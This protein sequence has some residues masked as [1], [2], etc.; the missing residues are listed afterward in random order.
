MTRAAEELRTGDAPVYEVAR[1][2][3]YD[4]EVSF[5]KAFTRAL[6]VPPGRYRRLETGA[7]LST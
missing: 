3:G 4:S 6:G 1:R 5:S 7:P 2:C